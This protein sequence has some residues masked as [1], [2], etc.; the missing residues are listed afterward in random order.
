MNTLIEISVSSFDRRYGPLTPEQL[1][2]LTAYT[3]QMVTNGAVLEQL[4]SSEQKRKSNLVAAGASAVR[5]TEQKQRTAGKCR[6]AF[7]KLPKTLSL[8]QRLAIVAAQVGCSNS[9][10][11]RALE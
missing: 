10:V 7:K 8:I 6:A 2:G 1:A 5:R 9:T 11:R 3:R 4:S